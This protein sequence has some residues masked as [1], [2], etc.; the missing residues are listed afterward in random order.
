MLKIRYLIRSEKESAKW[1]NLIESAEESMVFLKKTENL[2]SQE[3]EKK[4][5]GS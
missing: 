5:D 4:E 3:E 2:L 1:K